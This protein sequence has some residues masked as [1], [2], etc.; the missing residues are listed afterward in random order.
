MLLVAIAFP[1]LQAYFFLFPR[2]PNVDMLVHFL[3]VENHT[4]AP[5]QLPHIVST[6]ISIIPLM[7]LQLKHICTILFF[8]LFQN[9]HASPPVTTTKAH[10]HYSSFSSFPKLHYNL[11]DE[12]EEEEEEEANSKHSTS[13]KLQIPKIG[14]KNNFQTSKPPSLHPL[15]PIRNKFALLKQLGNSCLLPM[16]LVVPFDAFACVPLALPSPK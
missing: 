9:M 5:S 15:L 3:V 7:L 16:H 14:F 11:F 4:N 12:E 6:F 2:L 13:T 8:L 1:I 10:V